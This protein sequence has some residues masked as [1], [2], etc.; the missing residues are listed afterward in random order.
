MGST[1]SYEYKEVIPRLQ[2]I[3]DTV[4]PIIALSTIDNART[5]QMIASENNFLVSYT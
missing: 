3:A 2:L 1:L 4:S 5:T